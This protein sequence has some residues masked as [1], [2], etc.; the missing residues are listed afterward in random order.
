MTIEERVLV[1]R[2]IRRDQRYARDA[3][4]GPHEA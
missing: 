2:V 4:A 1:P 3:D